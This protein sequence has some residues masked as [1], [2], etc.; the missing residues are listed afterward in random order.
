MNRYLIIL[1][2]C[3]CLSLGKIQSPKDHQQFVEINGKK[4]FY[5]SKGNGNPVIVFISGL[6]PTMDD[7]QQ[8]QKML[9]K[10]NRTICYDRAGIGNSEPSGNERNLANISAELNQMLD[11]IGI[12][13]PVLL[14]GHSRGGLIARYFV[15]TYPNNVCGMVLIDP[16]LPEHK[17]LKR[18][19]RTESE[20]KEFDAFYN[21]FITDSINYTATIRNEFK[22]TFRNDSADVFGKGFPLNLPITII[23]SSQV[24]KDKYSKA[25][26]DLK[27]NLLEGYL[28]INPKIKLM[29]TNKSGHFIYDTEPKLVSTE[30]L[31]LVKQINS[32]NSKN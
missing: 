14:V 15:D 25:E 1:L 29:L 10:T 21:S 5:L 27:I 22:N 28:K 30:I 23:G 9:S 20:K 19:L 13:T 11:A 24:T 12:N 6:G 26:T 8:L 2:A 31:T 32:N 3:C 7:F 16:A 17:W 18:Q 4:Q